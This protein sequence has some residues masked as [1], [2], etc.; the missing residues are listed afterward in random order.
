MAKNDITTSEDCTAELNIKVLNE[1]ELN[2][3]EIRFCPCCGHKFVV[4]IAED[5]T[6][7]YGGYTEW[8][9]Q[10]NSTF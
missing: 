8:D 10:D 6:D 1:D 7:D 3:A 4:E 9:D 5:E 2:S